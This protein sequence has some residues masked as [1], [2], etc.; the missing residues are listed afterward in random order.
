M[1]IH[2]VGGGFAGVSAAVRL[3][4]SGHAVHLFESRG[5]LGGRCNSV[6][7]PPGFPL[8]LD[9]GPHLFMGAYHETRAL[10][11]TLRIPDPFHWIDP[12]TLAWLL[13]GGRRVSLEAAP[14]PAPFH[15][16]FGLLESD[17][18]SP[19]DKRR[20]VLALVKL[21][22]ARYPGLTVVQFVKREGFGLG[23]QDR[24]WGPLTRAI[25]N[26]APEQAPLEALAEVFRKAFFGRRFDSA[27]AVPRVPLGEIL[28]DSVA[29][30]LADRGGEVHLREGFTAM[31]RDDLQLVGQTPK[32]EALR[33]DA[34]VLAVPPERLA[35][36]LPGELWAQ[37]PAGLGKS[38]IVTAHL[39]LSHPVLEGHLVG[40][41]GAAFEWVFNRNANQDLRMEGQV[42]SLVC[43]ADEALAKKPESEL[44]ALAWGELR[45][46]CP[47]AKKAELVAGRVTKEPAATFR[48]TLETAPLRPGPSTPLPKV[49]LAGDWTDTGLPATVEGAVLSGRMAA[50]NLLRHP[51]R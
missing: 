18:F 13:P 49:V 23:A 3:A 4:E 1:R 44:L 34:W 8:P 42:L 33:A 2:V 12:L 30:Y 38:P 25:C 50:G 11:E 14:L 22:F 9:N 36:L 16:L 35:A 6:A 41:S 29:R 43:S 45:D 28:G 47:A 27:L 46:R 51:A 17:A 10:L 21:R 7:P 37:P 24:F 20:L 39:R 26:V 32:A 48:L 19:G 31:G 15:L 5:A 40:L